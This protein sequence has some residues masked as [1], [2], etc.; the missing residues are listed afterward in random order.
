VE[1]RLN[2]HFL[3]LID[4]LPMGDFSECSG[5]AGEVGT[6]EY[7]EGGENRFAH[8][9]PTRANFPNLVMK[10]GTTVNDALWRWYAEYA[11]LGRVRPR[12]GQ[13]QLIAWE[14]DAVV[15]VRVW[16]FTRGYPVKMTG[17]DLNAQAPAIA[18]E[19]V[20]VIHHGLQLV[21]LPV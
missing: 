8:R 17:P 6:E 3:L 21:T 14:G 7:L 13:V 15:P 5:L 19:T 1:P 9:F 18:I 20:E 16:A 4:G 11:T 10:R 12:D 2:A